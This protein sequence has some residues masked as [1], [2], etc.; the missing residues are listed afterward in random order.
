MNLKTQKEILLA[1][2]AMG[3]SIVIGIIGLIGII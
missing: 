2:I 1:K 3:A